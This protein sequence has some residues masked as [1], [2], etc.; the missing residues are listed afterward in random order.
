LGCFE[1]LARPRQTAPAR[2][3]HAA[4]EEFASVGLGD[5]AA[6]PGTMWRIRPNKNPTFPMA[7]AGME[8]YLEISGG[9]KPNPVSMVHIS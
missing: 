9:L 5:L 6:P 1:G 7:I 3:N 8:R 4:I 2:R